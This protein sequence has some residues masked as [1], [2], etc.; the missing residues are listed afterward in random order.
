MLLSVLKNHQVRLEDYIFFKWVYSYKAKQYLLGMK[1]QEKK[2]KKIKTYMKCV[3]EGL[4]V[5][6]CLLILDLKLKSFIGQ[7]KV[8]YRQRIP[9]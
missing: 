2:Y 9:V 4:T 5:K 8:F 7:R 1:L 6:R 3:S